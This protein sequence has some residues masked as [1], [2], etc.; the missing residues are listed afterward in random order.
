MDA[1]QGHPITALANTMFDIPVLA[2]P[3]V[4][5]VTNLGDQAVNRGISQIQQCSGAYIAPVV[6]SSN[7]MN[8]SR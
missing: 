3:L 8:Q 1:A 5:S 7:E 6:Q 2:G 4:N